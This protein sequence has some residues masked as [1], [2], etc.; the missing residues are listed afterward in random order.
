MFYANLK[1]GGLSKLLTGSPSQTLKKALPPSV[2]FVTNRVKIYRLS[3]RIERNR[4]T[5]AFVNERC[6]TV[7]TT[8]FH[9]FVSDRDNIANNNF[10]EVV[11]GFSS[12]ER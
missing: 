8:G 3:R 9:A 12:S 10:N 11:K 1:T 7:G 6:K 4:M 2:T 5:I